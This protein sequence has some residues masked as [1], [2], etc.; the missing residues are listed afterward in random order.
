MWNL[1]FFLSAR[2]TLQRRCCSE[3]PSVQT[4]VP[5]VW[6]SGDNLDLYIYIYTRVQPFRYFFI[7][8]RVW[9]R[10]YRFFAE[11]REIFLK[12]TRIPF[13]AMFSCYIETGIPDETGLCLLA[14][15]ARHVAKL[16]SLDYRLA[17]VE[18]RSMY[19]TIFLW[20]CFI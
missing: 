7:N 15:T 13:H 6:G 14:K 8:W 11:R 17:S 20:N 18:R 3:Q 5:D 19:S 9:R 1:Y 12:E 2:D 16:G 10:R 4:S